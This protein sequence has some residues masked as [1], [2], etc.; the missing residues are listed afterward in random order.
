MLKEKRKFVIKNGILGWGVPFWLIMTL[1]RSFQKPGS[2]VFEFGSFDLKKF[3]L[4][5]LVYFPIALIMGYFYGLSMYRFWEERKKD[6]LS[7]KEFNCFKCGST[8]SPN[9]TKCPNCGWSWN[10]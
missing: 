9:E 10:K 8:I 6:R 2:G 7:K 5:S 1:W 4:E 3:L